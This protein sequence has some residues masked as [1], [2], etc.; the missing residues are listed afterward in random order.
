M[1]IAIYSGDVSKNYAQ[2]IV[3]SLKRVMP[4]H[5]FHH[6]S[7]RGVNPDLW[8]CLSPYSSP[9][10]M[11]NAQRSVLWL[12][13]MRFVHS[14]HIYSLYDR[15]FR[16][17]LYR[18]HC[19]MAAR[20]IA[21]TSPSKRRLVESLGIEQSRVEV[22]SSLFVHPHSDDIYSPSNEEILAVREK[23]ELPS[24]FLLMVGSLDTMHN[25]ITLLHALIELDE[26]INVVICGRRTTHSDVLRAVASDNGLGRRVYFIYELSPRDLIALYRQALALIYTP[27]YDSGI[28]PI[29]DGLRLGVPMILSDTESNREVATEAAIYVA[30][31]SVEELASAIK[32]VIYN[33]S[34]RGQLIAQC[35]AES[36]RY[37]AEG[38]AQRLSEIYESIE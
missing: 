26:E 18:S 11:R 29:V 14:P 24:S 6:T 31:G 38:V 3:D 5:Q 10:E 15:I 23:F 35:R 28:M 30:S 12:S 4:Q 22:C 37:S 25:H 9:L 17:P 16:L 34:L 33:E 2:R 27:I 7:K 19:R 1:K 20:I 8:H 36:K 21:S 32:V 13:D